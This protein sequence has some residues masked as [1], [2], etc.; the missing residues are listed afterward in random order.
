MDQQEDEAGTTRKRIIDATISLIL[1]GREELTTRQIALEAGV[2]AA[3]INYHF[4]GKDRLIDE[5]VRAAAGSAFEAGRKIITA[6]GVPPLERLR[7]YLQGYAR[8][9]MKFPGLT[10]TAWLN[11]F[12]RDEE[13]H[14]ARW[15]KEMVDLLAGVIAEARGTGSAADSEPLALMLISTVIFPFLVSG[16]MERAGGVDYTDDE[17]RTRYID[18]AIR[19]LADQKEK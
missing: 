8:G 19:L 11:L 15:M 17:G 9:L 1:A 3:A 5:A 4:Q 18:T 2:N 12:R 10:R 6:P 7:A 13:T 14:Y 16:A